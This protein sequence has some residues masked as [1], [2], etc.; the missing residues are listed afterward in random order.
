MLDFPRWK[1]AWYWL[2]TL[3]AV[4]AALPSL[5]AL[6]S[7]SWPDVLPRPMVNLGLDLAG[8]SRILLEAD[9]GQVARQRLENMEENV[10]S[11]LRLAEPRIEL[12]QHGAE[13]DGPGRHLEATRHAG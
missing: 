9:R 1:Q 6:S 4:I 5:F 13:D 7:V 2:I 11:R 8:G 12:D 3:V 10:R